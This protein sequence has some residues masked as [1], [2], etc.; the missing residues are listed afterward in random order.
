MKRVPASCGEG[1]MFGVG[2]ARGATELLRVGGG[3]AFVGTLILL[4][5]YGFGLK[6][7]AAGVKK[8]S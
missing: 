5:V 2:I 4:G 7:C 8:L 6:V 1:S 3:G